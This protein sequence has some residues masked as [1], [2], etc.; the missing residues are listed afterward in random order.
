M[1]DANAVTVNV[2]G[3]EI[4]DTLINNEVLNTLRQ[5]SGDVLSRVAASDAIYP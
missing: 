3:L 5:N 2:I 1:G 4:A